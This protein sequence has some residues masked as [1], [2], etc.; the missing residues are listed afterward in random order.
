M[1]T[2]AKG[3]S[4]LG[5]ELTITSDLNFITT[6]NHSPDLLIAFSVVSNPCAGYRLG[7]RYD[8]SSCGRLLARISVQE[9]SDY[10]ERLITKQR[11]TSRSMLCQCRTLQPTNHGRAIATNGIVM[12][13][14]QY[15]RNRLR[16]SQGLFEAE[17]CS[18]SNVSIVADQFSSSTGHG[19]STCPRPIPELLILERSY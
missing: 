13:M 11:H 8:Y 19:R 12:S 9:A 7:M 5:V 15:A 6:S 16:C 3:A 17:L 1:V 18:A 10:Q 4:I 2:S 14:L